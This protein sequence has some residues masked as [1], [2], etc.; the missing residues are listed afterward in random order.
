MI[1]TPPST[2]SNPCCRSLLVR[3]NTPTMVLLCNAHH[4]NSFCLF[5]N[6]IMPISLFLLSEHA[7][8][9][10]ISKV[11]IVISSCLVL[12]VVAR[13]WGKQKAIRFVFVTAV[14][15]LTPLGNARAGKVEKLSTAPSIRRCKLL[16]TNR[17][18]NPIYFTES[19]W[20]ERTS[21]QST[22]HALNPGLTE[23]K[24]GSNRPTVPNNKHSGSDKY[25]LPLSP[26]LTACLDYPRRWTHQ[27]GL[28]QR[29]RT[30]PHN[31]AAVATDVG[32]TQPGKS[33]SH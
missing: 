30:G 6:K 2:P 33:S 5:P 8:F 17:V 9:F 1:S 21:L 11:L 3:S 18:L 12:F 15:K 22:S 24:T 16:L 25:P 19:V 4:Y 28:K 27:G 7:S 20:D 26:S 13:L 10:L 32:H 23:K 31:T 29:R 14:Q